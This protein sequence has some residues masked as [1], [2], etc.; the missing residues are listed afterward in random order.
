MH[1]V[2]CMLTLLALLVSGRLPA[3]GA[4]EE[5]PKPVLRALL[6][7]CD[8]FVSRP[9]TTP[10]AQQNAQLM[11]SLLES[12]ARGY[13]EIRTECDTLPSVDAFAQAVRETFA[14]AADSD[15]SFV[16]IST[17]G[18]YTTNR[19]KNNKKRLELR[20][21]CPKCGRQTLHKQTK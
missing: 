4:A 13:A 19:S 11:K 3:S 20:K 16:Y 14:G 18:L 5:A 9:E 21:F 17:H 6:V 12:D 7:T 15:I 10:A 1:R 2:L 8:R